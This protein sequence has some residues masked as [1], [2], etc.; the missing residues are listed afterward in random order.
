MF[1][2]SCGAEQKSDAKFCWNCGGGLAVGEGSQKP[3]GR[4]MNDD[5]DSNL[6]SDSLARHARSSVPVTNEE[7]KD[8]KQTYPWRRF[9]ATNIDLF[10]IGL[11]LG[12]IVGYIFG[13][14]VASSPDYAHL[15][16]N[17]LFWLII[18]MIPFFL[19]EAAVISA[20]GSTLGK[21]IFGITVLTKDGRNLSFSDAATRSFT[22]F[23][24]GMGLGIPLVSL[25][26]YALC[27][28]G[29]KK[30]GE[31]SW[32]KKSGAVVQHSGIGRLRLT[33]GVALF[34][35]SLIFAALINGVASQM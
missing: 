16:D 10:L 7:E 20:K 3:N 35:L 18:T 27:Y 22:K 1:C 29:L 33:A 21:Y 2:T 14:M 28:Q 11:P 12:V 34:V 6:Q 13:P 17:N 8:L 19:M 32:D 30:D 23:W 5:E 4:L 26:A 24:R 9:F 15:A 25:V 31:L